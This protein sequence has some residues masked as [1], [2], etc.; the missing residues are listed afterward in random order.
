MVD[1]IREK[2][3]GVLREIISVHEEITRLEEIEERQLMRIGASELLA[4]REIMHRNAQAARVQFIVKI[5]KM[6]G[7]NLIEEMNEVSR[8]WKKA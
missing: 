6:Y 4:K 7:V 3:L 5:G 8:T 2:R 1:S